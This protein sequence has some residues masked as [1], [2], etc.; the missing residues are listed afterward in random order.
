[1]KILTEE[2]KTK[3]HRNKPFDIDLVPLVTNNLN[4]YLST[5]GKSPMTLGIF[6][7]QIKSY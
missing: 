5:Y 1:M 3:N 6:P 2:T 7:N 4:P